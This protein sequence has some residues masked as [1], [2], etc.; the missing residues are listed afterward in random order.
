MAMSCSAIAAVLLVLT[1]CSCTS[2]AA[3]DELCADACEQ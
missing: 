2:A 1:F 3:S